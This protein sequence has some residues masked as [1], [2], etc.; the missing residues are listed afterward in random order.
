MTKK[1]ALIMYGS[2]KGKWVNRN[3]EAAK[4]GVNTELSAC[5]GELRN[6]PNRHL[7]KIR[8]LPPRKSLNKKRRRI[9]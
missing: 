3:Q 8:P 4:G 7:A 5:K 6:E 9:R 2:K 1:Q